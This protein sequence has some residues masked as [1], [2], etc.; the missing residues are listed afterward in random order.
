M[1]WNLRPLNVSHNLLAKAKLP[2]SLKSAICF[3]PSGLRA[4]WVPLIQIKIVIF[5]SLQCLRQLVEIFGG[6]R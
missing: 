2:S 6:G 4:E 3:I 5:I 1:Y